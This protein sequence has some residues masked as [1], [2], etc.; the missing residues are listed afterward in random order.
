MPLNRRP[1][2]PQVDHVE[3]DRDQRHGLGQVVLALYSI[4]ELRLPVTADTIAQLADM[5]D[6]IPH[7]PGV[8][9][10]LGGLA[11]ELAAASVIDRQ[12]QRSRRQH[13]RTAA[14]WD[15]R[16]EILTG[17]AESLAAATEQGRTV[18][19]VIW[20]V[21]ADAIGHSAADEPADVQQAHSRPA[22]H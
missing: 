12:E 8:T 15:R 20:D 6:R 2:H 17:V 19:T 11:T 7:V 1:E 22:G 18:P 5:L 9:L 21:T 3:L 10:E 16:Y 4:V 14:V 13:P